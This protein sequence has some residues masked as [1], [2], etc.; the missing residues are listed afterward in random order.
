M[1][2]GIEIIETVFVDRVEGHD[3]HR[4]GQVRVPADARVDADEQDVHGA[5]RPA[6]V[7]A[8][9]TGTRLGGANA[10]GTPRSP[11]R[12]GGGS[13]R[14]HRRRL[15]ED[16]VGRPRG[17]RW[18]RTR[19]RPAARSGRRKE[20][21]RERVAAAGPRQRRIEEARPDRD[22]PPREEQRLQREER[23][24]NGRVEGHGHKPDR[25]RGREHDDDG[26]QEDE[27]RDR[28]QRGPPA[29]AGDEVAEAGEDRVKEGWEVAVRGAA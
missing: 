12:V 23:R 8:T 21:D 25:G 27:D 11:A 2:R 5:G 3:D 7:T 9:A 28:E 16:L 19:H 26:E 13:D 6:S 22:E 20:R 14:R 1:S 17:R 15:D 10:P 18:S 24:E 29:P 4:V